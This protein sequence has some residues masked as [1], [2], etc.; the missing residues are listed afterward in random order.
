MSPR[1]PSRPF[2]CRPARSAP[3][4]KTAI[5]ATSTG[6]RIEVDEIGCFVY[7]KDRNVARAKVVPRRA[8]DYA[9]LVEEY[10]SGRYDGSH[11]AR[12]LPA[13]LMPR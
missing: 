6:R 13:I 3:T 1:R 12:R 7:A 9:M 5:C 2:S 8:V 10:R 4:T 11:T